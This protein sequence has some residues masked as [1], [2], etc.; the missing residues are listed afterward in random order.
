VTKK[1]YERAK[2]M[3]LKIDNQK[4]DENIEN[5]RNKLDGYID[6]N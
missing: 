4:L 1:Y 2:K 5:Y 3:S 6:S